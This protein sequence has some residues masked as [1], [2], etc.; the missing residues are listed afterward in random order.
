MLVF[1]GA[2]PLLCGI[3]PVKSFKTHQIPAPVRPSLVW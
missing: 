3:R 2:S 1:P